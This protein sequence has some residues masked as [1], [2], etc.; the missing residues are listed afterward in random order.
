M[1]PVIFVILATTLYV[2]A[3][4]RRDFYDFL[5][6]RTA[7]ER[8]VHAESLYRVEDGHYQ[9]KYWPAFA[10]AMAPFVPIHPEVARVAWYAILCLLLGLYIR[11]SIREL[12][13]RRLPERTL[14]WITA[15]LLA[16]SIVQELVNGQTNLLLGMLLLSALVAVRGGRPAAA[17]AFVGL[18]M[19]VKPYAV[20]V[21]PWLALAM[22]APAL[23]AFSGIV[24]ALLLLPAA[25]YGWHR[26]LELLAAW[27]RTVTETTAPNLL[28][29]ENIS[30]AA[31]W[32]KWVGIGSEASALAA[33]SAAALF[34]LWALLWLRR[35]P[36]PEPAYLEVAFL[37]L[38]VPLIS[39][40]GWDY[41]LLLAAPAFVCLVDRYREMSMVWRGVTAFGFVL[42]SFT[43]FDILGRALYVHL[44][45]WSA[46]T[47]G[48]VALAASLARLRW[49]ALA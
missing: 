43:V 29:R 20:I 7:G 44:M 10:L 48:A 12:P 39:P 22:G 24:A 19:F 36:V 46:I 26:N 41:V 34:G 23:I 45:E 35:R 17:G 27:Y 21:V 16:K 6:Y 14:A 1:W 49:R 18:G 11:R 32:A 2:G 31:F 33:L 25:A 42:T 38:L 4:R 3:R 30:L 40:Q 28:I 15:I 37:L 47:V 13:D 5:V 9:F 8:A